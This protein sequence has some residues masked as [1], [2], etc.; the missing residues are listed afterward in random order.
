MNLKWII[1]IG[2]VI[3]WSSFCLVRGEKYCEELPAERYWIGD[4]KK[5]RIDILSTFCESLFVCPRCR[6]N[7]P[8]KEWNNHHRR[9]RDRVWSFECRCGL[10]IYHSLIKNY[11]TGETR[12]VL[13]CCFDEGD[14][15]SVKTNVDKIVIDSLGTYYTEDYSETLFYEDGK[16]DTS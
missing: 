8:L 9:D 6:E 5:S 14:L 1:A 13:R 15:N 12:S 16:F 2:I 10:Y 11:Y 3:M 7:I 4:C